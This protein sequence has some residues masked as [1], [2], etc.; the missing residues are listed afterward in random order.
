MEQQEHQSD[1]RIHT[2]VASICTLRGQYSIPMAVPK[3]A[4]YM[5]LMRCLPQCGFH[6]PHNPPYRD[7]H[8]H[9]ETT[10]YE[11]SAMTNVDGCPDGAD[12]PHARK[13]DQDTS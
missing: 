7:M 3:E 6:T 2:T 10:G 1:T 8:A 13:R 4:G 5:D 12:V 9:T 11:R